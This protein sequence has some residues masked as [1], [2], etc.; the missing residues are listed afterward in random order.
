M[1]FIRFQPSL[2]EFLEALADHNERPWFQAHKGRYESD[3][4]TPALEFI[5]AFQPVLRKISTHFVASDQRVGGSLIRIYRDTRFARGLGPYK[6]NVGI[7]FRHEQGR[8]I[9][10]PGF[11][12]HIAPGECFL[13]AGLWRP[14]AAPLASIR[15]AIAEAPDRWR[16]A[17][18]DPAFRKA[19]VLDG[20]CLKR[21]PRG[22]SAELPCIEDI[23]RTD[24]V[25]IAD[26]DESAV[27]GK[28][29]VQR[30]GALFT[31]GRPFMRFLCG[32][33]RLPF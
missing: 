22:F 21:P 1:A 32:A 31:A 16:R 17:L 2:F 20:G 27:L 3:V 6:T 25:A 30:V 12:V 15:Q 23:K 4:L 7:Q 10:A 9:H 13:G 14:E 5:R 8:D 29:F 24:F 28:Q 19:F 18:R 26:L 11:Y 33:L